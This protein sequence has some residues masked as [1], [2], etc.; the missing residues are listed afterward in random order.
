MLLLLWLLTSLLVLD[1]LA[2]WVDQW[3]PTGNHCLVT[4]A[5][6]PWS[7]FPPTATACQVL[8]SCVETLMVSA[9][10]F[11]WSGTFRI[12][13]RKLPCQWPFAATNMTIEYNSRFSIGCSGQW[14]SVHDRLWFQSA[15][16]LSEMR[17][18]GCRSHHIWAD[19]LSKSALPGCRTLGRHLVAWIF[20]HISY[21]YNMCS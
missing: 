12:I 8:A 3:L 18:T 13:C 2:T 17:P 10:R 15:S 6:V 5:M 14:F 16:S 7:P 21:L 4:R 20:S 1:V 9:C 11:C 19:F